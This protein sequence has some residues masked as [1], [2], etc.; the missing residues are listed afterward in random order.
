MAPATLSTL[1]NPPRAALCPDFPSSMCQAYHDLLVS[2]KEGL[3]ELDSLAKQ[4]AE[5]R[6]LLNTYLTS[7]V[8]TQLKVPPTQI[9]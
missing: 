8:N 5:L 7:N 2:R 4:N 9:I 3:E 6:G 1:P